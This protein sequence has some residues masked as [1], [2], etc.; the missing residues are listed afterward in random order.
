M[1]KKNPA[2]EDKTKFNTNG[3]PEA[4]NDIENAFEE[5][6]A[7]VAPKATKATAPA[8]DVKKLDGKKR[9]NKKTPVV[10]ATKITFRG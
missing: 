10:S 8:A 3:A 4:V 7:P 2:F 9:I 5:E 1:A 6:T